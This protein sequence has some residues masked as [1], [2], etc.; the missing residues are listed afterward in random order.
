MSLAMEI[1]PSDFP[2]QAIGT[3]A[4]HESTLHG[5]DE[6]KVAIQVRTHF[7][8]TPDGTYSAALQVT[9]LDRQRYID[10]SWRMR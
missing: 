10:K 8:E 1:R 7:V 6:E 5:S 4:Q 2:S 3:R 9:E